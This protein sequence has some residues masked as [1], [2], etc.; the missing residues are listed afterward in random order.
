MIERLEGNN[1]T[2]C[3]GLFLRILF[4]NH[5]VKLIISLKHNEHKSIHQQLKNFPK[6]K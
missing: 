5:W 2:H 6:T 4:I 1:K 3:E